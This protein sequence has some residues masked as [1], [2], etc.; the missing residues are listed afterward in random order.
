MDTLKRVAR[1][2][3][4][5]AI[6]I[7]FLTA[8]ASPPDKISAAYVSPLQYQSYTCDQIR[9]EIMRVNRKLMEVSGAQKK[10]ASKD[11]VAMGV[12]LVIFWPALFFLAGDDKKEELARLKGEYDALEQSA[13]QK[14]CSIASEIE[15]ARREREAMKKASDQSSQTDNNFM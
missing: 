2:T 14:N 7:T 8:C 1:R 11:A 9:E 5:S 13:I 10:E 15:A 3:V 12:G 4:A 6:A